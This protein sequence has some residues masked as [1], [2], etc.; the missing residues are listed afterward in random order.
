MST[1]FPQVFLSEEQKIFITEPPHLLIQHIEQFESKNDYNNDVFKNTLFGLSLA[2]FQKLNFSSLFPGKRNSINESIY[3]DYEKSLAA[4]NHEIEKRGFKVIETLETKAI[5]D[6]LKNIFSKNETSDAVKLLSDNMSLGEQKIIFNKLHKYFR[7]LASYDHLSSLFQ[8]AYIEYQQSI[9]LTSIQKESIVK[10]LDFCI[11]NN[12]LFADHFKGILMLEGFF[13]DKTQEDAIKH[14][15]ACG[16]KGFSSSYCVLGELHEKID[17]F[18]AIYYYDLAYKTGDVYA[19]LMLGYIY[20]DPLLE[21]DDE[22][23]LI[24][25][26]IKYLEYAA[27]KGSVDAKYM[28]GTI[29][30]ENYRGLTV[31]T[32]DY[33]KAV[34]YLKDIY[35]EKPEALV[36]LGHIYFKLVFDPSYYNHPMNEKY[37]TMN[38]KS[39]K[40]LISNNLFLFIHDDKRQNITFDNH[41][42]I[43]I[44]TQYCLYYLSEGVN[45]DVLP[46]FYYL[47]FFFGRGVENRIKVNKEQCLTLLS[48]GSEFGHD[49]C[50]SL[51][52]YFTKELKDVTS[53]TV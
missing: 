41:P 8:L 50:K 10:K 48:K 17:I 52:S 33:T 37:L 4:H 22:N 25:K 45:L 49:G 7:N 30:Y 11:K 39:Y 53:E 46:C 12:F 29:Y 9:S 16:K 32:E 36:L 35:K 18:K 28:L 31:K 5:D 2:C 43:S 1:I 34:S 40:E 6:N 47:G 44:H 21:Y 24:P 13:S 38:N 19:A 3:K 23:I 15:L 42:G 14:F 26:G 27:K 51:L 20:L